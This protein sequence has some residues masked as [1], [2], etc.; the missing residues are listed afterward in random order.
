MG[1][2]RGGS[3]PPPFNMLFAL[4]FLRAGGWAVDD[5]KGPEDTMVE[6]VVGWVGRECYLER[7]D[8][9]DWKWFLFF[10]KEFFFLGRMEVMK[11]FV[12]LKR[13]CSGCVMRYRFIW[14]L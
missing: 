1:V 7:G 12:V 2:A 11:G 3:N 13:G 10:S 6:L 9:G 8:G 4:L 5:G 14:W